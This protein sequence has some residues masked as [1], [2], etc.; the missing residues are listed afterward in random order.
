M[1]SLNFTFGI[2]SNKESD[3]YLNTLIESIIKQNIENYEIIIVGDNN[4]N[5]TEENINLIPFDESFKKGWITK[6]K[7]LITV[8]AK[9]ENIV[10]LH[11]YLKL[12]KNW[13]DGFK[14]FGEDFYICTNKIINQNGHRYLDW[15]LWYLNNNR[16]D[17]VLYENKQRLIPYSQLDLS[18]YMYI[19]GA[20]FVAKKSLMEEFPL[21][22]KLAWGEGEDVEWSKRVRKKYNFEFNPY[23]Q[24]RLSKYKGGEFKNV[25]ENILNALIEY[26]KNKFNKFLDNI[27]YSLK[28]ILKKLK[29]I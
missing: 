13:Y 12:D 5:Y 10:Y 16:F 19:S 17:K 22:E 24:V 14:K 9:Y 4:L 8:N 2:I 3:K 21:N 26:D 1:N 27:I 15:S 6:K 7:N 29:I 23:S 28:K 25:E 20:Y 11:D 18:S